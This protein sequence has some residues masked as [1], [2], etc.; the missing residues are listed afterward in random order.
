[1]TEEKHNAIINKLDSLAS[2]HAGIFREL[3]QVREDKIKLLKELSYLSMR[4]LFWFKV[5]VCTFMLS[6]L[7]ILVLLYILYELCEH[8][9]G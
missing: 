6:V 8:L 5:F 4:A 7:I 3:A 2:Q 1:M 9:G